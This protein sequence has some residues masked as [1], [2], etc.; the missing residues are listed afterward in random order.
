MAFGHIAR[1]RPTPQY[2]KRPLTW[3]LAQWAEDVRDLIEGLG[4]EAVVLVGTS[5]GGFVVQHFLAAHP[6]VARGG[7]VVGSSP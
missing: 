1:R 2:R 4:L 3:T 6:G 7:V 5:F